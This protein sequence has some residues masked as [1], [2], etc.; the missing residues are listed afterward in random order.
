MGQVIFFQLKCD[1]K[2]A[3]IFVADT[4]KSATNSVLCD[5]RLLIAGEAH[6]C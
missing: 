3:V 6:F 5:L 1:M 4:V 2:R